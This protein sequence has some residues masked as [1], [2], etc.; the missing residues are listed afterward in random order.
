VL[1]IQNVAAF[2]FCFSY[3]VNAPVFCLTVVAVDPLEDEPQSDQSLVFGDPT[4]S[5]A[6]TD[7]SDVPAPESTASNADGFPTQ[8]IG[9]G[10]LTTSATQGS[11]RPT[12]QTT[13]KNE[14]EPAF[15]DPS[16]C[17]HDFKI[18]SFEDS[19]CAKMG[20]KVS[21]CAKCDT[22][23]TESVHKK[24]T[25]TGGKATCK[26]RAV[27][28]ACKKPYGQLGDHDWAH[29]N[30]KAPKTCRDCGITEGDIGTHYCTGDTDCTKAAYCDGCGM[31]IHSAR[32][33]HIFNAAKYGKCEMPN[34]TA[35]DPNFVD[36]SSAKV[37]FVYT[38]F[39]ADIDYGT[40]T[41]A[42][43]RIS[44]KVLILTLNVTR[45]STPGSHYVRGY[46]R[47]SN[48]LMQTVDTGSFISVYLN[49]GESTTVEVLIPN[50]ITSPTDTYHV[51]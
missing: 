46:Y 48:G 27:C 51:F 21:Y 3:C 28:T 39:P 15:V 2:G 22:T 44:G 11:T 47:I 29:A 40:I 35:V 7:A 8:N 49:P 23:G 43:Y 26:A 20:K 1:G 19:T 36:N 32:S 17:D 16:T 9:I 14:D 10:G 34:C 42:T 12:T 25:H 33:E 38:K 24:T 13:Q 30:C 4:S 50:V 31:L 37:D 6:D 45:N 18:V 41:A 5:G